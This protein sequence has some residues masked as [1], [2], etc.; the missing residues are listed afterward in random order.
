M[1]SQ[2]EI[3]STLK[4]IVSNIGLLAN[5]TAVDNALTVIDT[6]LN[7]IATALTTS[8]IFGGMFV[9]PATTLS[10]SVPNSHVVS[11]SAIT[12]SPGDFNAGE[13]VVNHAPYIATITPSVGFTFTFDNGSSSATSVWYYVGYSP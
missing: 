2:D 10:L 1:A 13:D 11:N 4:N 3:N 5:S 12:F 6:S 9:M 7:A 8:H